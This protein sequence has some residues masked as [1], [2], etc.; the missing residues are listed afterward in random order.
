MILTLCS[1]YTAFAR[2]LT[3]KY[4]KGKELGKRSDSSSEPLR[5]R[6][7]TIT[8]IWK[9]FK[10]DFDPPLSKLSDHLPSSKTIPFKVMM[11]G[12]WL[13]DHP[14][15]KTLE[16]GGEWLK[17]FCTHL[18]K[19]NLHPLDWDHLDELE[20]WHKEKKREVQNDTQFEVGS[21]AQVM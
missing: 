13:Q 6:C 18:R 16:C 5:K 15:F 10:K 14:E 4:Y 20:T 21:S 1:Q 3:F 12:W 9:G 11:A 17:G 19:D 8:D 7:R 2:W